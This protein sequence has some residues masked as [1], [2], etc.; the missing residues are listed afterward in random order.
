MS[1]GPYVIEHGDLWYR[2]SKPSMIG[3]GLRHVC[4]PHDEIAIAHDGDMLLKAGSAASVDVW[5][6]KNKAKMEKMAEVMADSGH[7][8]F[9]VTIVRLP[10]SQET[11]EEM[12]ACI[13]ISGRVRK[14]AENLE[15]IGQAD[16]SL[17]SR[18]VYPR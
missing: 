18:P 10:I 2:D 1:D 7:E 3:N 6:S 14:L 5:Y 9:E 16:P 8:G 11:V 4:G 17:F 15:R 13:S 12:N